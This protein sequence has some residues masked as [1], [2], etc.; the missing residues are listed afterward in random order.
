MRSE[1]PCDKL[2][3]PANLNKLE[4]INGPSYP[5]EGKSLHAETLH[6]RLS[7]AEQYGIPAFY[8]VRG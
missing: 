7:H 2:S 8:G 4:G 6:P 5:L 1:M 3:R